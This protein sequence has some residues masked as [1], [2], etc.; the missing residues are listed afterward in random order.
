MIIIRTLPCFLESTATTSFTC[1]VYTCT[2]NNYTNITNILNSISNESFI[3][4]LA[5]K[6]YVVIVVFQVVLPLV[7]KYFHAHKDYFITNPNVP[8]Q[9]AGNAS[10]KEKEMTSM[11]VLD[12]D[13][14][15][16]E[17]LQIMS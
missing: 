17:S 2:L 1:T 7:E 3:H 13:S 15:T 4:T 11:S 14:S 5:S 8:P 12:T 16:A 10:L 6:P 9:L